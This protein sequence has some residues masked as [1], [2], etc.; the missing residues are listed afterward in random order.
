MRDEF[1][2]QG[3]DDVV[4]LIAGRFKY[5]ESDGAREFAEVGHLLDEFWWTLLSVGFVISIEFISE[6]LSSCVEDDGDLG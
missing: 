6:G 1:C 3:G 2:G 5:G 4:S